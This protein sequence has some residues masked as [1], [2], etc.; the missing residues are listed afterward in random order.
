MIIYCYL[1]IL[2]LCSYIIKNKD[3]WKL[4]FD[5]EA[6]SETSQYLRWSFLRLQLTIFAKGSI[7]NVL[8]G[9]AKTARVC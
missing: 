3:V 8:L 4:H 6:Y 1:V 9:S 7:L 5:T 2:A